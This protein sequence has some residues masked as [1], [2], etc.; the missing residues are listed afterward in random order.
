MSDTA[1]LDPKDLPPGHAGLLAAIEKAGGGAALARAV[2]VTRFAVQQ[3]KQDG[4][5]AAR[6]P[7]VARVTGLPLHDLRPDLFDAPAT[8]P[9][10]A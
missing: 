4:V 8:A 9:E 7:A 3:W 2:G 5:P 10:A 6:V 1:P